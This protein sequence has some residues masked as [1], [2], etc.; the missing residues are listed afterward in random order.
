MKAEVAAE[1]LHSYRL[2]EPVPA[3]SIALI[4]LLFVFRVHELLIRERSELAFGFC[5]LVMLWWI[6]I[7][8]TRRS[9][10]LKGQDALLVELRLFDWRI[11]TKT[12]DLSRCAWVRARLPD[13]DTRRIT[14]EA[15][16]NGYETIELMKLSFNSSDGISLAANAYERISSATG[17]E[18]RGYR[19]IT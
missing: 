6:V 15:G 17:L 1:P 7:W 8:N 16:T 9:T 19:A 4:V 2:M 13:N 14:V 12:I 11:S 18:N 3:L 5:G 10:Y